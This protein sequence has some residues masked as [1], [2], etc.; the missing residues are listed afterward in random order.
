MLCVC[1]LLG[2]YRLQAQTPIAPR[3]PTP[4]ERPQPADVSDVKST[5][6]VVSQDPTDISSEFYQTIIK[7]N[8][9]APLGTNLHK[10]PVPGANLKLIGTFVSKDAVRSTAVIKNEKTGRQH[11]LSIGAGLGNLQVV[12]IQCQQVTLDHNGKA[13]VLRLPSGVLLNAKRR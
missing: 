8:L 5:V 11:R 1:C 4:Q 12:E 13:I 9:F 6:R 10:K 7:N 2:I 3:P